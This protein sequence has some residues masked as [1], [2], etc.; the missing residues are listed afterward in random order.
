VRKILIALLLSGCY[1]ADNTSNQ[2]CDRNKMVQ[3]I[4]DIRMLEGIYS[5]DQALVDSAGGVSAQYH[6]ILQKHHISKDEFM[7]CYNDLARNPG[8]IKAI[9]DSVRALLERMGK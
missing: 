2:A 3:I 6:F 7:G 4:C 8:E 9:E 5:A 1:D